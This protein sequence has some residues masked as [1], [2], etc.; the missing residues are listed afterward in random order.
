MTPE[1]TDP[2]VAEI[3]PS[4][5]TKSG[6]LQTAVL[7]QRAPVA[8]LREYPN[9]PVVAATGLLA[10]A[11]TLAWW[12]KTDISV[13]LETADIR[14]G[15]LWR[16]LTSVFPHIDI[17]HLAFNVY[18]L[19]IFG[20]AVEKRLGHIRTAGLFAL[21]AVGSNSLDFAFERGGVGLS[22]IG[23][24]LFGLLWVLS[25]RDERFRGTMD[26]R[27]VQTFIG[28]FF[29]CILL[30]TS[31]Q[32]PVANVAHAAGALFGILI[33]FAISTP[34]QRTFLIATVSALLLF[35]LSAAT[36]ARP[37]VNLSASGGY[38]EARW[39]YQDLLADR[40]Q[41]AIPWLRD[42]TVY[43]PKVALYWYNLG[44]AYARVGDVSDAN[45]AFAHAHRL[46]PD[47][48]KF[49]ESLQQ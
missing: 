26:S 19:W 16:L 32:Y 44:L 1:T 24:G 6:S 12:S 38:E 35:G 43:K 29:L 36:I 49:P 15:Q 25:K 37:R 30:T 22:G 17:L 5:K 28:W 21:L 18:W 7:S 2:S 45:S 14:R 4:E 9:Y 34:K 23:Y 3:S 31:K 11:V 20:T 27:T 33:G 10:I 41:E 39:G 46:E 42:S 40:N 13:L 47:N 48:P 8:S